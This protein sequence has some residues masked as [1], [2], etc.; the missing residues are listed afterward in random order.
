MLFNLSN[1]SLFY[2]TK[3][4]KICQRI[5]IF[6][7]HRRNLSNKY[8]KQILDTA[9]KTGLDDLETASK[10][11]VHKAAEATGEFMGNKITD[12]IV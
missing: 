2:R 5:F 11:V 7:I 3:N 4:K 12:K 6:V 9:A 1:A 10:K 8:G